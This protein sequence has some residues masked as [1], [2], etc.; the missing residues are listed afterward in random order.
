MKVACLTYLVKR[1]RLSVLYTLKMSGLMMASSGSTHVKQARLAVPATQRLVAIHYLREALTFP[2]P[3]LR[4]AHANPISRTPHALS[5]LPNHVRL[6]I[7]IPIPI[8]IPYTAYRIPYTVYRIPMPMP[9]PIPRPMPIPVPIA[10]TY[11]YTPTHLYTYACTYTPT[12]LTGYHSYPDAPH[13]GRLSR[14]SIV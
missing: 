8:P 14:Y 12:P 9:I 10:Y 6:P 3:A 1:P 7:P 4:M 13:L 11:A 2:Q 5:S